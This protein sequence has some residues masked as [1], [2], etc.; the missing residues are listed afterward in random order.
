MNKF[1]ILLCNFI[2][3]YGVEIGMVIE[4]VLLVFVLVFRIIIECN[5]WLELQ[6]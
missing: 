5:Q 2:M 6:K 3:E 1:G 4:L